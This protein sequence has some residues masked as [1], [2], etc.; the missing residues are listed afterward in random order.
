[1]EVVRRNKDGQENLSD[2]RQWLRSESEID[3]YKFGG[4]WIVS[5]LV[6]G[7][8]HNWTLPYHYTERQ[9]IQQALFGQIET[10]SEILYWKENQNGK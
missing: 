9:A 7:A 5:N 3:V 8:W 1:M 2:L 10:E 4:N 6:N